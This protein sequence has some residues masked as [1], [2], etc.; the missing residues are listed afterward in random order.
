MGSGKNIRI[1]IF[2]DAAFQF[3]YPENIEELQRCGAEIVGIN[4]LESTA[5]PPVD[6]MGSSQAK[7][8]TVDGV[9]V[10]WIYLLPK[11]S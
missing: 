2:R 9:P 7:T 11:S 4:A 5:L 3:Y 8:E 1:G 6:A 10:L